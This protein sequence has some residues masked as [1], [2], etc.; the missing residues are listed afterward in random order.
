[1]K[2]IDNHQH[3]WHYEPVKDSC[4]TDDMDLTK[5]DFRHF[6]LLPIVTELGF[7]G[8]VTVQ[9]AQTETE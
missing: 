6:D 9:V 2:R 8:C 4:M 5:K 7:E 1:M 3:F